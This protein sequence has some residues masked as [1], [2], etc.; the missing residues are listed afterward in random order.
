MYFVGYVVSDACGEEMRNVARVQRVLHNNGN[1][2]AAYQSRT[3]IPACKTSRLNH[4]N[5]DEK[6]KELETFW[7]SS[8]SVYILKQMRRACWT[9]DAHHV[10]DRKLQSNGKLN[11]GELFSHIF[12]TLGVYYWTNIGEHHGAFQQF[13]KQ[14]KKGKVLA[15]AL[16]R[17][18]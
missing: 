13:V 14:S 11:T 3:T 5:C 1:K 17:F 4:I 16:T 15:T 9:I 8:T 7:F 6:W 2:P 18:W 12:C 10:S